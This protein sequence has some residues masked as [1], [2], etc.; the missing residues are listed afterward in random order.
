MIFLRLGCKSF[1]TGIKTSTFPIS[2]IFFDFGI[3]GFY[4]FYLS[5]DD[6]EAKDDWN[7]KAETVP[8]G[9]LHSIDPVYE[10]ELL[11]E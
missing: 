5:L 2:S 10:P 6:F 4:N 3:F 8:Y 11:G 7:Y 9:V 1:N